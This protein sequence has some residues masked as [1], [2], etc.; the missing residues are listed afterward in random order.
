VRQYGKV[1]VA[2]PFREFLQYIHSTLPD[3]GLG[4]DVLVGFP[5]ETDQDFADK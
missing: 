2:A 1:S 5:G 4:I 3:A